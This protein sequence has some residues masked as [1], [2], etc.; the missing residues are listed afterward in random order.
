VKYAGACEI[1][2]GSEIRLRRVEERISFHILLNKVKQDISQFPKEIIS[3]STSGGYFTS[4][5]LT[6]RQ[7]C[8]ILDPKRRRYYVQKILSVL[9]TVLNISTLVS[10]SYGSNEEQ[11][12]MD[13]V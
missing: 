2:C 11:V 9:K 5:S 12:G 6:P 10:C 8:A 1:A 3:H 7:F 4:S 13:I